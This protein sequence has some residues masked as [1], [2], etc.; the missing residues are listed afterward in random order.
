MSGVCAARRPPS[1]NAGASNKQSLSLSLS[2][3]GVCPKVAHLQ[4]GAL[5]FERVD[6]HGHH[7]QQSRERAARRRS[8]PLEQ[9]APLRRGR[10]HLR[11]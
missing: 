6:G 1:R 7:V 4:D 5:E 3:L 11:V 2:S 10:V 9:A 8:L